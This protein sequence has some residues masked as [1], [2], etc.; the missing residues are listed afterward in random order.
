M[1]SIGQ[2]VQ[3][4]I[5]D[6]GQDRFELALQ[7]VAIALDVTAKRHYNSEK[8]SKSNYKRFLK[9]YSWL[10]ELMAFNGINLDD[11]KFGN[12][13]I[14]GNPEPTFQ[15]LIYHV[16]RC[17]LVH[18]EGVPANFEFTDSDTITLEKDRLCFPKRLIWGLIA[19]VVFCP[20]NS[21]EKTAEGYWVSIFD[22]RF[23]INDFWGQEFA[24]RIVYE[25]RK[26]IRVGIVC[27][28][29]HIV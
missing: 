9:E 5:D 8:S 18:D 17:N 4:A 27:P 11:S 12:F 29:G 28:Q 22:N 13:P 26:P 7:N 2:R 25:K 10:I 21:N 20:C 3:Y 24:A 15:D 19:V 16:I 14:D 1:I 23:V 6:A